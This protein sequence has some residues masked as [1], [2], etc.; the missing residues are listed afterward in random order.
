MIDILSPTTAQRDRGV[1]RKLYERQGVSEYWIVD[2]EAEAVEVWTFG[3]A[4]ERRTAASHRRF[5]DRLP[6]RLAADPIGEIDL[7]EVFRAD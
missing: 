3:P 2:P 7:A 4:G 1:K 5:A 6:V